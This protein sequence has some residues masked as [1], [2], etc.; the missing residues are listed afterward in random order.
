MERIYIKYIYIFCQSPNFSGLNVQTYMD[1]WWICGSTTW[2]PSAPYCARAPCLSPA[3]LQTV[4]DLLRVGLLWTELSN[5]TTFLLCLKQQNGSQ[6]LRLRAVQDDIYTFFSPLFSFFFKCPVSWPGIFEK[7]N[8]SHH[9]VTISPLT[10]LWHILWH[11]AVDRHC[12]NDNSMNSLLINW[13]YCWCYDRKLRRCMCVCSW[14][15]LS[16]IRCC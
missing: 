12:G 5:L 1:Q 9:C 15:R 16:H 4:A 13:P 10:A 2:A 3:L 14:E 8:I 11:L 6:Q 7:W